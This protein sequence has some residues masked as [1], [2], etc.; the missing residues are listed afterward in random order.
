MKQPWVS[1]QNTKFSAAITVI[2]PCSSDGM[3]GTVTGMMSTFD[4]IK[5]GTGTPKC[6][7]V[8]FRGVGH[9]E[10]GLIV[11]TPTLPLKSRTAVM[12]RIESDLDKAAL[13][14]MNSG[15]AATSVEAQESAALMS[16]IES[17][18]RAT[19]RRRFRYASLS[20]LQLL[21]GTS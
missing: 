2:G 10:L 16:E 7:P 6:L 21:F 12:N 13:T 18:W 15:S 11:A 5:H 19:S 3:L 1:C 17:F 9:H 4:V 8:V 14:V 20:V